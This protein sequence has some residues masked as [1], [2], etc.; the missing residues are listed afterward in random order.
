MFSANSPFSAFPQ[1]VPVTAV[2]AT[3]L[4]LR[5]RVKGGGTFSWP[6]AKLKGL[7]GLDWAGL[8]ALVADP[9]SNRTLLELFAEEPFDLGVKNLVK[10]LGVIDG[11]FFSLKC[12]DLGG[13]DGGR[14]DNCWPSSSSPVGMGDGRA[15]D[16]YI[17]VVL[18]V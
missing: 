17:L 7:N 18:P 5:S 1:S 9:T 6:L 3:F 12:R 4:L 13:E 16:E 15:C 8:R 14:E 11:A 2:C 10:R